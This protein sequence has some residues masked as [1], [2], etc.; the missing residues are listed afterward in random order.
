M[1][2]LTNS[3]IVA[4]RFDIFSKETNL[5][6]FN[7]GESAG[8]EILNVVHESADK[9]MAATPE[10][11]NTARNAAMDGLSVVDDM[12]GSMR[13]SKSSLSSIMNWAGLSNSSLTGMLQNVFQ[14]SPNQVSLYGDLL[15]GCRG[16]S[17]GYGGRPYMNRPGCGGSNSRMGSYGTSRCNMTNYNTAM[18][19]LT[20]S[21]F[22]GANR[23]QT[24]NLMNM[25]MGLNSTGYG[26]GQCGVF[27]SLSM[28]SPF[29][30]LGKNELMKAAAGLLGNMASSKNTTGWL[31]I[32]GASTG[33][34]PKNAYPSV[35]SDF[36]SSFSIPD[37]IRESGLGGLAEQVR[38]GFELVDEGWNT[39]MNV[40]ET[41]IAGLMDMTGD[42]QDIF[43]TELLSNSFTEMD[44][45]FIPS[46]DMDFEDAAI[47]FA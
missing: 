47:M 34:F 15:K 29:D 39:A 12:L 36:S 24:Q 44:L 28:A 5:G 40:G 25:F 3:G 17:R 20:G 41:S 19:G 37:G 4:K 23:N 30:A 33:L 46:T 22:R 32:A 2:A 9:L 6:A 35:I 11:L 7:F 31:D 45:D 14:G 16:M 26:A 43:E 21:Q 38:G 27:S 1:P 42:F 10:L 8:S 13:I 18:R